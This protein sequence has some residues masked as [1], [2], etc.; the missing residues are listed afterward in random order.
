MPVLMDGPGGVRKELWP[1]HRD[2]LQDSMVPWSPVPPLCLPS[3][4]PTLLSSL[5]VGL[6]GLFRVRANTDAESGAGQG[7]GEAVFPISCNQW[8]SGDCSSN[9]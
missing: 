6:R 3:T 2:R 1:E 5:P 7:G 8:T 9:E 4:L